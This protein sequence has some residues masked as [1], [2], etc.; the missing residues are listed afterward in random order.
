M[1]RARPARRADFNL[2]KTWPGRDDDLH[3]EVI[4]IRRLLERRRFSHAVDVGGAHRRISVILAEFAGEVTLADPGS[5]QCRWSGQRPLT[6]AAREQ[7]PDHSVDLVTMIG[8]PQDRPDPAR[9]LAEISRILRPGGVAVI[10]AANVEGQ[11]A[12]AD[13]RLVRVLSVSSLRHP[14]VTTVVPGRPMLVAERTVHQPPPRVQFRPRTFFLLEKRP[15]DGGRPPA[16][17]QL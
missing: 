16:I 8:V 10:E 6:D 2:A 7:F 14:A 17:P 12:E 9:A 13:L 11:L 15:G 1:H 3:A 4:A 5:R